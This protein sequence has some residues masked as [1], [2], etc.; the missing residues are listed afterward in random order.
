VYC[1]VGQDNLQLSRKPGK[2][3]IRLKSPKFDRWI[4]SR[5]FCLFQRFLMLFLNLFII[6]FFTRVGGNLGSVEHIYVYAQHALNKDKHLEKNGLLLFMLLFVSLSWFLVSSPPCDVVRVG[7]GG[8][9]IPRIWRGDQSSHKVDVSC[10]VP[11]PK[12]SP[13]GIVKA[14]D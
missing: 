9:C 14:H 7:C 6:L 11:S 5:P 1:I 8:K 12:L 3:K 2:P 4:L 13:N 10:H